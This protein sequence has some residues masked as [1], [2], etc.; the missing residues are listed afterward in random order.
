MIVFVEKEGP[1][2]GCQWRAGHGQGGGALEHWST[3]ASSSVVPPRQKGTKMRIG[4]R[5]SGGGRDW[6]VDCAATGSVQLQLQLLQR[7][8]TCLVTLLR[9]VVTEGMASHLPTSDK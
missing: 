6:K 4:G 8:D 7:A 2:A 9:L 5:Q 3:G 1:V